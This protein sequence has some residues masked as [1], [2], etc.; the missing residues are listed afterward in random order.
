[1]RGAIEC[2]RDRVTWMVSRRMLRKI[3]K[4][5]LPVALELVKGIH[6]QLKVAVSEQGPHLIMICFQV[7]LETAP[8]TKAPWSQAR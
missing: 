1:M 4:N 7:T 2:E 3:Q 5:L 8:R 6:Q